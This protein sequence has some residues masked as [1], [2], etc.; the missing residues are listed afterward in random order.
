MATDAGLEQLNERIAQGDREELQGLLR[1]GV[2]ADVE[3]TGSSWGKRPVGRG[4]WAEPPAGHS[5][6]QIFGSACSV[7][8][9]KNS[10]AQLWQP[11]AQLI[12]EASYEACLL[13]AVKQAEKHV[14]SDASNVV[15]LTFLGGGVFGNAEVWITEAVRLAC[16]KMASFNLDVRVVQYGSS[17]PEAKR[18]LCEAVNSAVAEQHAGQAKG[19]NGNGL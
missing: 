9:S 13:A 17:V 1:I 6:T 2:H 11:L 16:V 12:L 7:K 5:V 4:S 19:S 14:Y 15:Y 18:S 10:S 3:V 8:Y